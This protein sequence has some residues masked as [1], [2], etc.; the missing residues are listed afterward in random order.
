MTKVCLFARAG[1][2]GQRSLQ[3]RRL[4]LS[5]SHLAAYPHQILHRLDARH[6]EWK[7]RAQPQARD[8]PTS[9]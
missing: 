3:R 4:A 8:A 7:G 1:V 6:F 5:P 9:P 2:F